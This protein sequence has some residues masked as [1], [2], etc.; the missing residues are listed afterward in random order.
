MDLWNQL[1]AY[2]DSNVYPLHM[3]GHKRN[4][5]V[6]PSP[7]PLQLDITE[8]HGFDDLHHPQG[9][10]KDAMKNAA[11]LWK[12]DHSFLLVNGSSGGILSAIRACTKR[13]DQILVARNCHRSVYHGMELCGLQPVFLLPPVVK[14]FGIAGSISPSIVEKGLLAN[15]NCNVVFLTSPTY[16]G[17][18]C[19]IKGIAKVVHEHGGILLV[20][21]A[22]GAHLGFSKG[23]PQSAIQCGADIVIQSLHKTLPSPTQ[24]AILHIKGNRV[25]VKT[26]Q[27]QL[28]VFQTSSPSYLLL[29]AI[30]SCVRFLQENS[31]SLF[32]SYEKRLQTFYK[33]ANSLSHLKLF[34]GENPDVFTQD[35]GKLFISTRNTNITG[36]EL[37][38]RLRQEFDLEVEMAEKDGVLAMTSICDTDDGLCRLADALASIDKTLSLSKNS[39]TEFPATLPKVRCTIE[40]ALGGT[41]MN[42][43]LDS[44]AGAISADY[45]W[46]YPPGI[47]LII[48]GEEISPAFVSAVKNMEQAGITLQTAYAPE[49]AIQ[50]LQ[51]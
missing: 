28:S 51:K 36:V 11:Q 48:P 8:I 9:I 38:S 44:S 16:E 25:N 29:A 12:A 39:A 3:P 30:D 2:A 43:T 24:T 46:A 37:S 23:F 33:K 35:K 4:K 34:C 5:K 47:P 50:I 7:L 49:G 1:Q 6:F 31:A 10:L 13:N 21:E 14:D 27:R 20:D 26:V 22:H 15:P 40:D 18:V 19:D 17:V 41:P 32:D 45:L 42:K